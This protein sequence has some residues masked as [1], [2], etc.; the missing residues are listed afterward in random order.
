MTKRGYQ[1]A[2]KKQVKPM[3]MDIVLKE[4]GYTQKKKG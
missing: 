2:T 3:K 4:R 1:I